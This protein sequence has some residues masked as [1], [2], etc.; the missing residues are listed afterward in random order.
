MFR[1]GAHKRLIFRSCE[2]GIFLKNYCFQLL[3]AIVVAYA[4]T[5][6]AFAQ[7]F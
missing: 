3:M 4:A 1:Y 2:V 5:G 6:A 7:G